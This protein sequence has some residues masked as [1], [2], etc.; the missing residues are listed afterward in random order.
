MASQVTRASYQDS[1]P[2][3]VKARVSNRTI[4]NA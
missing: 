4:Q 1:N 3:N 2:L